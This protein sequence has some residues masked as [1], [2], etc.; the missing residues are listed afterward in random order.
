M[1]QIACNKVNDKNNN[2]DVLYKFYQKFKNPENYQY[3]EKKKK[4]PV[5]VFDL[6]ATQSR[7][8]GEDLEKESD[9][10]DE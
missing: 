8:V 5:Q 2:K 9:T 1:F 10:Q 4:E 7:T 3:L 6:K